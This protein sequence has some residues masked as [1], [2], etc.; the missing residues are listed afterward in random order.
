[1]YSVRTKL[2]SLRGI[3]SL[4]D[5]QSSTHL[6]YNPVNLLVNCRY[7]QTTLCLDRIIKPRYPDFTPKITPDL[8][9]QD[10]VLGDG[11]HESLY[12]DPDA[13][14]FEMEDPYVETPPKCVICENQIDF[15]YK[16]VQL[17]SQFVSQ[18]TGTI[19]P[20]KVVGLC[21]VQYDKVVKSIIYARKMAMMTHKFKNQSFYD[22]A[23]LMF[24]QPDK[25]IRKRLADA[26]VEYKQHYGVESQP[27]ESME[28][29]KKDVAVP[30]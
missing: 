1:M 17:L 23:T 11:T 29:E 25:V 27:D 19:Y 7:L 21:T 8:K 30:N 9:V 24:P 28:T 26:A 3:T 2:V 15:D 12:D 22:D 4:T 10:T 20:R 6:S 13:P 18:F 16:N 14:C 5:I